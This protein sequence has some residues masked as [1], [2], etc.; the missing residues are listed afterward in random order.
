MKSP[1]RTQ[2]GLNWETKPYKLKKS[3]LSSRESRLLGDK[4]RNEETIRPRTVVLNFVSSKPCAAS[5]KV[6]FGSRST[7]TQKK[8]KRLPENV[9]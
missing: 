8:N 3:T 6:K 1:L 2:R 7:V 9:V 4:K 5:E